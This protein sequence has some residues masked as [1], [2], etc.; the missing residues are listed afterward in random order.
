MTK[1][2]FAEI[3]A[4]TADLRP[5][6]NFTVSMYNSLHLYVTLQ[7]PA[8]PTSAGRKGPATLPAP[9]DDVLYEA[10]DEVCVPAY[11]RQFYFI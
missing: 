3:S 1:S 8:A 4:I 11:R 9:T 5:I 6:L 10:T 7:L 2:D